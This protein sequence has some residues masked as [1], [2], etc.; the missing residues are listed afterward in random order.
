M[1][2]LVAAAAAAPPEGLDVDGRLEEWIARAEA[3]LDGPRGCWELAGE[4][5]LTAAGYVP[6]TRWTRP[7][8]ADHRYLGP[9]TAKVVDGEWI[10]FDAQLA[11]Q[12]PDDGPLD[13][14]V[15]PLLGRHPKDERGQREGEATL[16]VGTGGVAVTS[17]GKPAVNTLR[18]V[19]E[20]ID[21]ATA[22][23]FA[24]WDEPAG[25]VQVV[26][27]FPL[28]AGAGSDVVTITTTIPGAG[29]LA[30]GLDVRFPSRVTLGDGLVKARIFDAQGH[31]RGT[32]VGDTALPTLES[33][34][35][36]LGAVGFTVGFE[37]KIR[38][39]R[40]RPCP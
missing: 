38:Y 36:S 33:L 34:S 7:G 23:A 20:E 5:E 30:S 18:R 22:T 35:F 25:A 9:F 10:A 14:P 15:W 39:T 40:A 19:L 29:P 8:R 6:A 24:R 16:S 4:V 3:L 28:K 37:Q 27:D 2:A 13:L 12:D 32:V 11:P 26:Q 1:S 17:Q 21:P 31:V